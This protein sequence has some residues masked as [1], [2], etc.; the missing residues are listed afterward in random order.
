[1]RPRAWRLRLR[2]RL[3]WSLRGRWNR[4]GLRFGR[5]S[6]RRARLCLSDDGMRDLHCGLLDESFGCGGL[7]LAS[8]LGQSQLSDVFYREPA[9]NGNISTIATALE[10]CQTQIFASVKGRFQWMGV[11]GG[12]EF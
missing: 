8:E 10:Q 5:G 3:C 4:R 7:T 2:Q 9:S 11:V 12:S 6:F 1:M